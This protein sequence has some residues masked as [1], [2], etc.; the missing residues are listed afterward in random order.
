MQWL[1]RF[2]KDRTGAILIILLGVGVA[3]QGSTYRMGEL[4]RMGAGYMPVVYGVLMAAVGVLLMLTAKRGPDDEVARPEWRGWICIVAGVFAFVLLGHYGGFVPASFAAV[5]ISAMG[6]K[7]NNVRDAVLLAA[8][9]TLV[10]WLIFIVG[11]GMPLP[12]FGWG[13]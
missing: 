1:R 12:V 9:I 7:H 2:N 10:G 13:V 8:V 3:V 6:D 11:L 4:T 5:F